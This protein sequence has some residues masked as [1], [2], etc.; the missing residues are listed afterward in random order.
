[1]TTKISDHNE[2]DR[3]ALTVDM[4]AAEVILRPP[5]VPLGARTQDVATFLGKNE[6]EHP[7]H[8]LALQFLPA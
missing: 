2:G 8:L 3:A 5:I 7:P 6:T 4:A 1:M